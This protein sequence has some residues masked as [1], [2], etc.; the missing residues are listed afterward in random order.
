MTCIGFI[1]CLLQR[2]T[3][4]PVN[5]P[6]QHLTVNHTRNFVDPVTGACTNL[7]ECYWKNCKRRFK[8]MLGVQNTML[9]GHL[10]EF[11]WREKYGKTPEDAIE[12]FYQH[13]ALWY[14]V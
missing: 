3:Q 5:P 2:I 8:S 4:L 1:I 13:T 11:L 12:A 10:D 7:V 14:P 9:P 6:Y